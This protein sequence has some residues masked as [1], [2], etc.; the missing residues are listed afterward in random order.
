MNI[1]HV[2]TPV[3]PAVSNTPTVANNSPCDNTGRISDIFVSIPP[4]N[5]IIQRETVPTE[6]ANVIFSKSKPQPSLPKS[7]PTPKNNN[8]DGTPHLDPALSAK[9]LTKKRIYCG[10]QYAHLRYAI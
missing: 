4:E 8:N 1:N 3:I 6:V 5:K 10:V 7:I 9:I 2:S